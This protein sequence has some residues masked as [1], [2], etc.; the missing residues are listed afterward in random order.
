MK[1]YAAMIDYAG[2]DMNGEKLFAFKYPETNLSSNTQL[3][4]QQGQEAL[5][6]VG[7]K[8]EKKFPP[9]GVRPYTLDTPN[10]PVVRKLFGIP[11]GG[12]NPVLA[13]VWFINK[14]DILNIQL[15][16]GTILLKDP[17]KV[18][19]FP[20]IAVVTCGIH[21]KQS[22]PFLLKL[23]NGNPAF[24]EE[25]MQQALNGRVRRIVTETI[26][27]MVDQLSLTFADINA[28][29]GL[30]SSK[31]EGACL[32]F[33][34]NYGLEFTD[35]QIAVTQDTSTEGLMM[36]SGYGTDPATFERQRIL[37]I[38][39]QAIDQMQSGDNGL[40]GAVLAM[41]MVNTMHQSMP[42]MPQ[43]NAT[44]TPKDKQD[45]T[46]TNVHY[47]YCANCGSKYDS[48][49]KFCPNCGKEYRPCPKCG[50]DTLPDSRRCV[51]CGAL[52]QATTP[53]I[54][55]PR[56][57]S[58]IS[59]DARFCPQCG[60]PIVNEQHCKKCGYLLHGE[61]YCPNCGTKNE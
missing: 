24:G 11:F 46:D 43:A 52:L 33:L 44:A 15:S 56:C 35:F 9:N 36:A 12:K 57:H 59:R 2:F 48:R 28:R 34:E 61:K 60:A 27:Q 58:Q 41:G 10:L 37:D 18:Q 54:E 31:S 5:L 26:A 7:G 23:V 53:K 55:C 51:N 19:G 14:A 32:S 1:E 45:E 6:L 29:L 21:V 49:N 50:S 38:Q 40:L 16:T 3:N 39:E 30:I 42:P 13:S 25:D 17:T 20:A 8:I 47:V 22:E 4:V